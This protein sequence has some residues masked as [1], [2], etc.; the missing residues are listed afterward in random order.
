[1]P[2]TPAARDAGVTR[3][4]ALHVGLVGTATVVTATVVTGC[5]PHGIDRRPKPD[6][7]TTGRAPRVDPDVALAATVLADEQAL[8][9]QVLATLERHPGLEAALAG[10]RSAHQ[11][12]VELLKDAVPDDARTPE[13]D[14]GSPTVSPSVSP[15]V[16]ASPS[17]PRVPARVPVALGAVARAEDRLALVGRRS[18]FAAQSGAFARV[19]AS[20]AAAAAQQATT[21]ATAATERR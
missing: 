9:D 7:V 17:V 5:T 19:L 11:A 3:R 18:S 16:G 13:T 2:I 14:P 21:L 20:M 15:S 1:V 4:T 10:A 8:L 12:H 6:A